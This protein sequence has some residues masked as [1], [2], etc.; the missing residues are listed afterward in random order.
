VDGHVEPYGT[1]RTE[2]K[3]ITQAPTNFMKFVAE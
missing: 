1:I 2:H 3:N